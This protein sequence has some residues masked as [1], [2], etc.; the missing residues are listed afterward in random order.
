MAVLD[1]GACPICRAE[2]SLTRKTTKIEGR[3]QISY[4]CIECGS[5]LLWLGG[6]L[7]LEADRWAYQ[8]VGRADKEY[9]LQQTLTAS[10]LQGMV[11]Q[12]PVEIRGES[13]LVDSRE[14]SSRDWEAGV[15]DVEPA[16][17]IEEEW[18]GG[19]PAW[20]NDDGV[21]SAEGEWSEGDPGD[22]GGGATISTPTEE[23]WAGQAPSR[24]RR[25]RG[26][27]FLPVSV[28]LVLVCLVC[29][30]AAMIISTNLSGRTPQV[31]LP[32][33]VQASQPAPT[34]TPMPTETPLPTSTVA[35]SPTDGPSVQFQ[36][37]SDYVSGTGSHYVVG[38]VLNTTEDTLRFVEVLASFYDTDGQLV[39][40]GSTFTEISLVEAGG[41]APFKLA[42]LDPPPSLADYKLRSDHLTTRDDPV[43]LEVVNESAYVDESGWHHVFGEVR[44]PY[45]YAVKFA[46]IV[47]TYYRASHE[48]VRVEVTFSDLD[49]LQ[50]GGIS[51]FEIVLV[52]PPEDLHHY[53]L[54]TEAVPE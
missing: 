9:L 17:P 51:A 28:G 40:T 34:A 27:P 53:A 2:Y 35:P 38:E 31:A 29:S 54:Q 33:V 37:V 25:S 48:V 22:P 19:P 46:E 10:D 6:D 36:G 26:S 43:R 20:Q 41:I 42:T 13:R 52:D 24:P 12:D 15:V 39:G 45:D 5:V 11:S 30:S 16:A 32:T 14:V 49:T 1:L 44:N 50:P 23:A 21:P 8:K 7:W 18:Y 3:S 47:A 4:E